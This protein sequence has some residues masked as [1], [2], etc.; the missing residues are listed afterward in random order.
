MKKIIGLVISLLFFG[1]YS[2]LNYAKSTLPPEDIQDFTSRITI[3]ADAS[4]DVFENIIVH[5]NQ[6]KIRHGI[7]RWLPAYYMDGYGIKHHT[8]Y[9]IKN[10][11]INNKPAPYHM[12]VTNDH[13]LLNIGDREII[14]DP[15]DYTYTLQYHVNNTFDF[16]QNAD[17]LSWNITGNSWDFPI[18]KVQATILFPVGAQ[19]SKYT[20]YTGKMFSQTSDFLM[21]QPAINQISFTTTKPLKSGEGLD[22]TIS[23]PKGMVHKPSAAAQLTLQI[24]ENRNSSVVFGATLFLFIYYFATWYLYSRYSKKTRMLFFV[25]GLGFSGLALVATILSATDRSIAFFATFWLLSVIVVLNI[26]SYHVLRSLPKESKVMRMAAPI[27]RNRVW[28]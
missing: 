22:I 16:L 3:N 17:E 25:F 23:W 12:E 24:N 13:L 21:T 19:I 27:S 1:L 18:M 10:I 6:N 15:G 14:L 4:M 2:S 26:F 28:R 11:L 8:Q 5:S 7:V 20:A 9:Q